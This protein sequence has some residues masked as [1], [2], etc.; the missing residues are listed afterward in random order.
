MNKKVKDLS[1]DLQKKS[2]YIDHLNTQLSAFNTIR[3][4]IDAGKSTSEVYKSIQG[5]IKTGKIMKEAFEIEIEGIIKELSIIANG[6][7]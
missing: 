1:T 6:G 2:A 3:E 7:Q 5:Y 4:M